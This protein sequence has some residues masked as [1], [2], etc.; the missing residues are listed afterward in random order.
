MI[1]DPRRSRRRAVALG[2]P[3]DR[4]PAV[5][6]V[7]LA[8]EIADLRDLS[9][10]APCG[11]LLEALAATLRGEDG[12]TNRDVRRLRVWARNW[13]ALHRDV[14]TFYS[15][16]HG[17]PGVE[18]GLWYLLGSR[19]SKPSGPVIGMIHR[20]YTDAHGYPPVIDLLPTP[21]TQ[22]DLP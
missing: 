4:P 19:A 1:V 22:E 17:E 11:V 21:A 13:R 6:I 14:R 9:E 20:A 7:G 15:T 2:G 5:I 12:L 8:I 18:A 3:T 10:W 16:N